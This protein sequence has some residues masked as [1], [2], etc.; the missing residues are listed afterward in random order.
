MLKVRKNINFKPSPPWSSSTQSPKK[1]HPT[2]VEV[3]AADA[4]G[5][6]TS[7]ATTP[8]QTQSPKTTKMTEITEF[9]AHPRHL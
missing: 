5:C 3:A 2:A 1:A 4:T 7:V 8:H 6:K 9:L